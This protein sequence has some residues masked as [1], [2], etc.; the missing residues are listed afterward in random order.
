[1]APD[2]QTLLH[3]TALRFIREHYALRDRQSSIDSPGGCRP[4]IWQQ[5][6]ALG[7]L[8]L[9]FPARDGGFDGTPNDMLQLMQ[10]F[11][12]GL[13]VEPYLAS[14]ILAG[15]VI[16]NG[17]NE[18]QKEHYLP[19]LISGAIRLAAGFHEEAGGYATAHVATTARPVSGGHALDGHKCVV[20]GASGA[21]TLIVSARTGGNTRD[22]DGISLFLVDAQT[23]GVTLRPYALID[24]RHAAD[25]TLRN[26]RVG[27]DAML[28]PAGQGK[29][30]VDQAID[31]A[32][33]A[34]IGEAVGALERALEMTIDYLKTRQQFGKPLSTFQVLRHRVV[35]IHVALEELRSLA[36]S[37]ASERDPR[38][39]AKA[40]S[41]AKVHIGEAG[42]RAMLDTIQL[43][44]GIGMTEEYALGHYVRRFTA[45]DRLFGGAA[46]HLER[47][48]RADADA[49][50]GE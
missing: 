35:D 1:M 4:A 38:R 25:V 34:C 14:V 48:R 13:V 36:L 37:A 41:A 45:I 27:T 16:L 29:A 19:S 12:R 42:T 50:D 28:G 17:G 7:W 11:G 47:F 2:D 10:A 21:D 49:R 33:L 9:P 3:D 5:F 24:G 46:E 22:E 43:H 31:E 20:L 26:V 6:A 23:D 44:G 8:G 39:R 40:I 30:L 18:G 15:G 32:T